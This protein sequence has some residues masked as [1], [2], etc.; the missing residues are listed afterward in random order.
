MRNAASPWRME[1]SMTRLTLSALHMLAIIVGSFALVLPSRGEEKMVL[2]PKQFEFDRSGDGAVLCV[3]GLYLS[4]QTKTAMC[5]LPRRPNDDAI[6]EAIVAI[7]EFILGNS[8]LKPTRTMLDEFKRRAASA[9]TAQ[10]KKAGLQNL[11]KSRD[12]EHF[13]SI[14]PEE[15]R[16]SVKKLLAKPREPVMNPCL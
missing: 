15:L 7:D 11:C 1:I 5:E 6:D 9:E 3:W 14:P 8:S 16:A 13:R 2:G 4:V 12:V 10:A